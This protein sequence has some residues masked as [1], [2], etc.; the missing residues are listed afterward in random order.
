MTAP[1]VVAHVADVDY[2]HGAA[3]ESDIDCYAPG[4]NMGYGLVLNHL[5]RALDADW[6]VEQ[7]GGGCLAI[8]AR[9]EGIQVM[10]TDQQSVLSY[11]PA[12]R[13]SARAGE[14]LGWAIGVYSARDDY[15]VAMGWAQSADDDANLSELLTTALDDY[16]RH[17]GASDNHCDCP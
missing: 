3:D 4:T 15:C 6:L 10:I 5:Y 14:P 1:S 11:Y 16:R 7:T 2:W 8:V 12:R 9:L 13:D 17:V